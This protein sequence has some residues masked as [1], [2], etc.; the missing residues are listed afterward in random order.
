MEPW[1]PG[2]RAPTAPLEETAPRARARLLPVAAVGA[3][4]G[5]LAAALVLVLLLA[6]GVLQSRIRVLEREQVP[7][8]GPT[9]QGTIVDIARRAQPAIVT[10]HV[11]TA[12]GGASGSGVIIRSDGY[13]ITNNH[14]TQ[15]AN[16]LSV[17]L[18]SGK[19]YPA[20]IVG[21]DAETD[22]A[23]VKIDA[24][25][26]L[27]VATLGSAK[28]LEVGQLGVA[29][30]SPLGLTGGPSVTVGVI[31]ALGRTVQTRSGG[32]P[33]LDM[34]QTDAPISPGS[35]G[36]ALLND[37]GAVIGIT[38]AIAVSE[39]G[40]EGLGFATPIDIA[41]RVADQIINTGKVV[42]PL[43]G[44]E[45][46]TLSQD[47]ADQ[48]GVEGG[49]QVTRVQAGTPAETTGV[50]TGDA[51]I[52]FD[53]QAVKNFDSLIVGLRAHAPGDTVEFVILRNG[54]RMTVRL[55]LGARE[56]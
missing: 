27:P 40:A 51:I 44:I 31:S 2:G 22:I 14:V 24:G 9:A 20:G 48:L 18:A 41:K 11:Q 6:T 12:T 32:T 35:S 8:A 4:A 29:I 3:G 5:A 30:G 42:H 13:V 36:G 49:A 19:S 7:A 33:L 39:V 56:N 17:E 38:T 53:G 21:A 52:S 50:R 28:G 25:K 34:V 10:M 37:R 26:E 46:R 47:D 43:I 54:A 15:G 55:T 45:G 1:P 16:Q 23:V